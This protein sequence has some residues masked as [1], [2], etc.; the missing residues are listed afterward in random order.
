MRR[1]HYKKQLLMLSFFKLKYARRIR[2]RNEEKV[3]NDFEDKCFY[4]EEWNYLI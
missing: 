1:N 2:E 4:E 3:L